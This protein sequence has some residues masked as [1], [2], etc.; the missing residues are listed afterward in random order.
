VNFDWSAFE[1]EQHQRKELALAGRQIPIFHGHRFVGME[2]IEYVDPADIQRALESHLPISFGPK[3][4]D[5][6]ITS[7][8][9]RTE[10]LIVD[11]NVVENLSKTWDP[12]ASGSNQGTKMGDWTFGH[13]MLGSEVWKL[14]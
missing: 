3:I 10:L 7:V 2:N 14:P 6:T 8:D 5:P 11:P 1:S 12:C 13:L 9:A 4:L